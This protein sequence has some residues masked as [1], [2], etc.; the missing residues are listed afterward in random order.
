MNLAGLEA[1]PVDFEAP[2]PQAGVFGC[3]NSTKEALIDW[4]KHLQE[5]ARDT[6]G[7]DDLDE[8][9]QDTLA[10]SEWMSW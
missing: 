4:D 3:G 9:I 8:Y 2:D 6:K 7:G 10:V 1:F 5:R